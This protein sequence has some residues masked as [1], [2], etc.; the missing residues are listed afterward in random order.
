MRKRQ[1][2][3]VECWVPSFLGLLMYS[4]PIFVTPHLVNE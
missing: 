3:V 1:A 2:S 4:S